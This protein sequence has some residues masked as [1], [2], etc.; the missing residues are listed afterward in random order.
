MSRGVK[1]LSSQER[2]PNWPSTAPLPLESSADKEAHCGTLVLQK[3]QAFWQ[4]LNRRLV[5]LGLKKQESVT[6]LMLLPL[7]SAPRKPVSHKANPVR[8][9]S[10]VAY[11]APQIPI[12]RRVQ[13]ER[14]VAVIDEST[15]VEQVLSQYGNLSDHGAFW[16]QNTIGLNLGTLRRDRSSQLLGN[17]VPKSFY[18]LEV[19]IPKPIRDTDFGDALRDYLL[20]EAMYQARKDNLRL[21]IKPESAQQK[22]DYQQLGFVTLEKALLRYVPEGKPNRPPRD[23]QGWLAYDGFLVGYPKERIASVKSP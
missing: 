7:G 6:E 3:L 16:L 21:L 2:Y 9:G 14:R 22:K 17:T 4:G 20:Q 12:P 18:A 23:M 10:P 19:D 13:V 1:P 15:G 5:A 11:S 8:F